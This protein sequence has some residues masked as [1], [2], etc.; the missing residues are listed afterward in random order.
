MQPNYAVD[1]R[2][3]IRTP[4]RDGV[5]LSSDIYLP[6]A[7]GKF[8]TVLM[9]TPYDNNT[10]LMI[11]KAM[12]LAN[13]GYACVIQDV[14]GRWDSDGVHYALFGHGPDG[15]DTQEWIGQQA[16]SDGKIGMAGGSYLGWV[17]WQSAPHR[18][19]HLTCIA[20]RVMCGDLYSG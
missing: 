8:P 13:N 2:L 7:S 16:W 3:N 6:Q 19:Q 17:Q 10:S 5:D 14:R 1:M 20:P 15:F 11:E 18:S 4:M 12:R 9:R